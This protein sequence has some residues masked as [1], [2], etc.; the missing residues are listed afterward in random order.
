MTVEVGNPPTPVNVTILIRVGGVV[1]FSY[2]QIEQHFGRRI[3]ADF[4][5]PRHACRGPIGARSD[6]VDVSHTSKRDKDIARQGK[7]FRVPDPI[8][9]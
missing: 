8:S 6:P 2:R 1:V 5:D 3:M 4:L 9:V 7:W